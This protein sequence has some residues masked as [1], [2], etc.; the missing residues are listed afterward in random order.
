MPTVSIIMN[1]RNGAAT[2]RAALESAFNQTYR[3]WELIVWDDRSSDDSANVVAE[4]EDPRLRY[5]LA[6]HRTPLGQ[7]RESALGLARGEW[8]AFLDQD[9]IWLPSKLELQIAFI[10][11]PQVGLIY[12]RTLCFYPS[13]R[14]R[15]YDQFHEFSNLPEGDIFDELLG[16]GCF[17]AMSSALIRRAAIEEIGALPAQIHVTP[18]YFWYLAIS[19]RY[20]AR[21]VQQVVCR[22]RVHPANM[23][24]LYRRE[25]LEETLSLIEAWREQLP[26]R[27]LAARHAGVSTALAVEEMRH[28]KSLWRGMNRFLESGSLWWLLRAPLVRIWRIVGRRVRQPFWKK[29]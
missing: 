20:L 22:Y 6:P 14:H 11:A 23:T 8:L 7:A 5:F 29:F 24:N 21:A 12:G 28:W 4:F 16:R 2:L 18:D 27:A 9:D 13:G 10:D 17:I 1:V 19:R 3:D 26:P 15:D 25:S